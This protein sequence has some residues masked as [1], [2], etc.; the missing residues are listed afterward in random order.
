MQ[1][2]VVDGAENNPPTYVT[3]NHHTVTKFYNHTGHLI[4]PEIFV[5]S[6]T[7]WNK[8][9]AEDQTLIKKLS[10]EAQME[11]RKLW[12]IK[13]ADS[14]AK[15][16]TDGVTIVTDVDYDAF[17][18]ATQPVRDKYGKDYAVYIGDYL[19]CKCFKIL[20][21]NSSLKD[22]SVD[23]NS[24]TKIVIGEIDQLGSRF[25]KNIDVKTYLK[26]ISSK[27]AEL[28]SLSLYTGASSSGCSERLSR[29]LWHIGHNIGMAFQIIDD[30]LDYAGDEKTL[31]KS[32]G[33]D[34]KQ[35]NLT[36][37]VIYALSLKD[38]R[39]LSLIGKQFYTEED[40]GEIIDYV[41]T[42]GSLEASIKLAEKY[43]S[44]A[45]NLISKLPDNENREMLREITKKLLY[46]KY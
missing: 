3:Q 28:F 31:G 25:D 45:V 34:L 44:K 13:V 14:F 18:K 21:E 4:I 30:I 29:Q 40:I 38:Q 10:R 41:K 15:M 23:S 2:G 27:T 46:R 26:R 9:S 39:F 33:S 35:G 7:K 5:F 32:P 12:D 42:S 8:L 19:L 20:A 36:L 11:Q 24:M 17:F 37:P 22:I 16:K 6:K 43:S 1:T